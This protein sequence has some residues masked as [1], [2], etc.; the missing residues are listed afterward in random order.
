MKT[1]VIALL[2]CLA[3]PLWAQTVEVKKTDVERL[4][5]EW[6]ANVPIRDELIALGFSGENLDLA[7]AHIKNINSD[8]LIISHIADLVISAYQNPEQIVVQPDGFILPLVDQGMGHLTTTELVYFYKVEQAILNALPR[9]TCGRLVT[10]RLSAE[11]YNRS[12]ATTAARLN[13]AAL[14]EYYRLQHKAARLGVSHS[15]VILTDQRRAQIEGNIRQGVETRLVGRK[16]EKKL[17]RGL[18]DPKSASISQAC[19]LARLYIQ[20]ALSQTGNDLR[21]AMMF[22]SLP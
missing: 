17:K 7:S 1:L 4:L 20:E 9:R 3:V 21:D 14:R 12:V 6:Q 15:P 16:D 11:H 8:P 13:T 2:C 19:V 18:N 22:L 5:L 10:G